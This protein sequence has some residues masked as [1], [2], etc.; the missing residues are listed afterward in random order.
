MKERNLYLSHFYFIG[1]FILLSSFY[2]KVLKGKKLISFIKN[3]LILVIILLIGYYSLY[4][5]DYFKWNVFEISITSVPL[6]VYSFLF[7]TQ[8][9]EIKTSRSFIYFNSGFFVYLLSS[10]LLF[11]LGNIGLGNL[12][13]R[14]IKLF[15]WKVNSILYIIYQILVFLEWYKNFRKKESSELKS[16]INT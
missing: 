3:I 9:I 1:Q 2:A 5:K 4:P 15:V 12:E 14:P 6:L 8:R 13:L 11:T 7:F 10:T 16:S